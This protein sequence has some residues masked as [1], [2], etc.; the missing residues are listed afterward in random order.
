MMRTANNGLYRLFARA[1][2]LVLTVIFL[3]ILGAG[4]ETKPPSIGELDEIYVFADSVDWPDYQH[5]L[6]TLF[7]KITLMPVAEKE[8]LIRW[9]PFSEFEQ[10]KTRKNLML[11]ARLDSKLPVSAEVSSLLSEE[12]KAGITSGKYFYI[13][14]KDV[15]ALEQYVVFLVAPTKNDMIQRLYDLGQLVYDDF[16]KAYYNRLRNQMFRYMENKDLEEY[17]AK[18]FPFTLRLQPDYILVD[19]SLEERYVWLRRFQQLPNGLIDRSIVVHWMPYTDTIRITYDWIVKQRNRLAA[20][21][22]EGDVIVEEE[23]RLVKGTFGNRYH[24]WP[25]LRLE[26]TWKNMKHLIGG[27]FRTIVFVDKKTNRIYMIDFYVTAPGR[28]KKPLL[29]QLEVIAHSF[30]LVEKAGKQ[31]AGLGLSG[32]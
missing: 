11:I 15:W 18:H 16:E 25:C 5:A 1:G 2:V 20:K 24:Q 17:L 8:Y 19:E 21:L 13:P 31:T 14:Q 4:C 26:G 22:Y 27:P 7:G 23:T 28:R 3:G 30:R 6:D 10:Y 12:I 9:R 32:G 29:D